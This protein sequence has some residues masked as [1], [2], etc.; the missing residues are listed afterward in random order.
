[1][2]GRIKKEIRVCRR[3]LADPR[4]P[5]GSRVLLGAAVTYALS[6]VDLIPDFIP[7]LGHLDDVILVP[8]LLWCALRLVPPDV[9]REARAIEFKP[10]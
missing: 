4:T 2:L 5:R 1:M 7:V 10:A 6:P 9:I 3:I 8:L